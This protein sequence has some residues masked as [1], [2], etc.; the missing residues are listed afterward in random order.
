M[1]ERDRDELSDQPGLHS[2]LRSK[3]CAHGADNLPS[4]KD[5]FFEGG[6]S[7]ET[8]ERL[9]K[10]PSSPRKSFIGCETK[11]RLSP[12]SLRNK[13]TRMI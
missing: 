7:S 12:Y 5:F 13:H 6:E 11:M 4:T 10:R 9:E 8:R 1:D 2:K 3:R